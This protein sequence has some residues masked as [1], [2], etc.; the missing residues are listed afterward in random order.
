MRNLVLFLDSSLFG[1][2]ESHIV[3]LVKLMQSNNVPVS[4]LFYQDHHNVQLYTLLD[5]LNC[6]YQ[7]LDG[8]PFSLHQYLKQHSNTVLHTHGYKAG[9]IG[10]LTC[11]VTGN[12]CIS[13]YHAGEKGAGRVR[14]YNWLDHLTSGFSQNLVVAQH[15]KNTVKNSEFIANFIVPNNPKLK[16][17]NSV[18]NIAFVGRLS[19]EKGPD[20]FIALAQHFTQQPRLQFHIYGDGDMASELKRNAPKNI[21]FH[22]HQSDKSLWQS[23]DVLVICSREEGLPMVLLEAMD[24]KIVCIANRV[25]AIDSVIAHNQTGLLTDDQ[26][27]VA[28]VNRLKTLLFMSQQERNYLIKNATSKLHRFYAGREQFTQLSKL[29]FRP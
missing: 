7:C 15:L 26:S 12:L 23:I 1:G 24:N 8:K 27:H 16:Q 22:G 20:R 29:Y 28:L 9:I 11:K 18:L 19:Y 14:L 2:I 6:T 5:A 10:R 3:E 17:P 13:T 21:Q 25:G 4:V